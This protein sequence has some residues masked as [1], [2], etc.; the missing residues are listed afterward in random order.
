MICAPTEW[1][2]LSVSNGFWNTIWIE[3]MVS[4]ARLAMLDRL[5]VLVA[6]PDGAFGRRLQAHQHLGEGRLAAAGLADD[7]HGFGFAGLEA[8]RFVRLD[9]AGFAAAEN[10]AGGYLVIFLDVVDLEHHRARH[11]RL[12]LLALLPEAPASRF[13]GNRSHR[14]R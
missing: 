14:V 3:E 12:V 8:D 4:V 6:E 2:G 5:D 11:G 7:G 10:L 13:R 1:L 9:G